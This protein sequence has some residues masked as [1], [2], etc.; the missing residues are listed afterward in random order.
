[1]TRRPLRDFE[2]L[3]LAALAHLG[4]DAHGGSIRRLIEGRSGR[5]VSPGAIYTACDRLER[6]GLVTS[7][8]GE[9]TPER[10]GKR[11]RYYR[12]RSAGLTALRA[13]HAAQAAMLRGL[14]AK[15]E[16]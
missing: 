2:Q 15:L 13:Q 5:L 11:K 6:R 7:D 3:L 9:P 16:P 4:E 8:L 1:M 10:G 12:L 14:K